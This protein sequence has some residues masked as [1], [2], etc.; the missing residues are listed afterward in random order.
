MPL[1]DQLGFKSTLAVA[2]GLN[3][4]FT[5]AA[6]KLFGGRAIAAIAA[7]VALKRMFVVA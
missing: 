6:F 7:V 4:N 3:I 1:L 2:S 5:V